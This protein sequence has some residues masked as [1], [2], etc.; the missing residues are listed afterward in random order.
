MHFFC[1]PTIEGPKWGCTLPPKKDEFKSSKGRGVVVMTSKML[2]PKCFVCKDSCFHLRIHLKRCREQSEDVNEVNKKRL[3]MDRVAPVK[4]KQAGTLLCQAQ[5][6]ME[7]E[8]C[9]T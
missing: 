8:I 4:P 9:F 5:L 2:K 1:A 7:I 6:K 3:K